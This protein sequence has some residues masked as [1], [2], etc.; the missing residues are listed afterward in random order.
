MLLFNNKELLK[1]ETCYF[2]LY[3]MCLNVP[4]KYVKECKLTNII[5]IIIKGIVNIMHRPCLINAFR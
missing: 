5:I 4:R 1:K 3:N 2:F